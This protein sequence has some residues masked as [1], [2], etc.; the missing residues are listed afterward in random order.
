MLYEEQNQVKSKPKMSGFLPTGMAFYLRKS[1]ADSIG[2]HLSKRYPTLI[3]GKVNSLLVDKVKTKPIKFQKIPYTLRQRKGG[4]SMVDLPYNDRMSSKSH[5]RGSSVDINE[6]MDRSSSVSGKK[7]GRKKAQK[8]SEIIQTFKE[9][10][11]PT[12][13]VKKLPEIMKMMLKQ[14]DKKQDKRIVVKK[15]EKTFNEREQIAIFNEFKPRLMNLST[16]QIN[17]LKKDFFTNN[18][19]SV[20]D[21]HCFQYE[22]LD[23]FQSQLDIFEKIN[24]LNPAHKNFIE[25]QKE[26][27]ANNN[28]KNIVIQEYTAPFEKKS[29]DSSDSDSDSNDDDDSDELDNEDNSLD[30]QHRIMEKQNHN[31]NMDIDEDMD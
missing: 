23:N 10:A 17:K 28:K 25:E 30:Y 9:S 7:K 6:E 16:E 19:S 14:L 29:K 3:L 22:K 4:H 18:E 21:F 20:L 15:K 26:M 1:D 13:V 2:N 12:M 27:N 31:T 11:K 5:S 24:K 8:V